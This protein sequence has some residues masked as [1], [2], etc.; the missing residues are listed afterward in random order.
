MNIDDL[1]IGQLKEIQSMGDSN[2]SEYKQ[3]IGQRPTVYAMNYIYTGDCLAVEGGSIV[4]DNAMIV[5][6]T[7]DHKEPNWSDAEEMRGRWSV[8]IQS[9]ESHGIFK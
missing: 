6:N 2:H 1:T 8:A 7:G 3:Y 4:F 5:Y 9:I